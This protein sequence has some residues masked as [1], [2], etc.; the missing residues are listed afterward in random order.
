M[1]QEPCADCGT[2]FCVRHAAPPA[3]VPAAVGPADH[4]RRPAAAP[5]VGCG[6]RP[7]AGGSGGFLDSQRS[8]SPKLKGWQCQ[9][10]KVHSARAETPRAASRDAPSAG[11]AHIVATVTVRGAEWTGTLSL[12]G[13]SSSKSVETCQKNRGANFCTSHAKISFTPARF[14]VYFPKITV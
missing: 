8:R 3:A 9:R 10:C 7:P 4:G 5:A 11:G 13:Q 14:S 1:Q 2:F 12:V 6:S